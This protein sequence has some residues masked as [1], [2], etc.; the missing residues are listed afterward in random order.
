M[1]F[2]SDFAVHRY[3]E[4]EV[5]KFHFFDAV[6]PYLECFSICRPWASAVALNLILW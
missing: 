1:D 4:M 6:Q 3:I 5:E 2:K